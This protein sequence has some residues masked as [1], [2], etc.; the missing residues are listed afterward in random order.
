M[1]VKNTILSMK[2][3]HTTKHMFHEKKK[4]DDNF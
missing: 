4:L 2:S 1:Q 3:I